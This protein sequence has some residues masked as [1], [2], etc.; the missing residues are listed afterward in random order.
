M[1]VAAPGVHPEADQ[2]R[3]REDVLMPRE[4]PLSEWQ[5][6]PQDKRE[7]WDEFFE[8]LDDDART[9]WVIAYYLEWKSRALSKNLPVWIPE[10][11]PKA[12]KY[13][14]T[15]RA[16]SQI[17]GYPSL[18]QSSDNWRP[19]IRHFYE[20]LLG[21]TAE[22]R[23]FAASAPKE[24]LEAVLQA[25]RAQPP[26]P[27]SIGEHSFISERTIVQRTKDPGTSSLE[28]LTSQPNISR[29]PLSPKPKHPVNSP[30]NAANIFKR[31]AS[32][33]MSTS[34]SQSSSS[35]AQQLTTL[36]TEEKEKSPKWVQ[37]NHTVQP[38][39]LGLHD[40]RQESIRS[41]E[42]TG[43]HHAETDQDHL[44]RP[45]PGTQE[46]EID[47]HHVVDPEL[48]REDA[49]RLGMTGGPERDLHH[50]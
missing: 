35:D 43:D 1:S 37:E 27:L 38:L 26:M 17:P 36:Q 33:L 41:E 21:D 15:D 40:H 39:V 45:I 13:A 4:K 46:F 11:P 14:D 16:K 47:L 30:L 10:L 18:R 42:A 29:P 48:L 22:A 3:Q 31:S 9:A 7:E 24:Q 34:A 2:I 8:S 23:H 19:D 50:A 6:L 32:L 44:Q 25:T 12:Q 49:L 28:V 20:L 5:L